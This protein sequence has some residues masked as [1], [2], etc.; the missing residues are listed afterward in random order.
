[1]KQ[2]VE[3]KT[4]FD[5]STKLQ[6]YA[7]N[8][9]HGQYTK[10]RK[11]EIAA[12]EPGLRWARKLLS[13]YTKVYDRPSEAVA[14]AIFILIKAMN[15]DLTKRPQFDEDREMYIGRWNGAI[16]V[17]DWLEALQRAER[18]AWEEANPEEVQD[19]TD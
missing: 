13:C 5:V 3:I 19:E 6:Y 17:K 15:N 11:S 4:V 14:K 7:H 1:M 8:I 9:I 10:M 18:E 2:P 12:L 16:H